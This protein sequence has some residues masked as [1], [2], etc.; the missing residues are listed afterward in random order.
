MAV[1]G[2]SAYATLRSLPPLVASAVRLADSLGFDHSCAP[3]HGLLLSVL[4]RGR[5]GG[6]IGET[7]TGCGVGLA[8][9]VQA[10]DAAT[11]LVSIEV[12][13]ERAEAS[14]ALFADYPNVRVVHGDW[15]ELVD[16]GPFDLLVPDGGGKGKDPS[17]DYPLD[18]TEGWLAPGGTIVL[19]DFI[20]TENPGH[21]STTSPANTGSAIPPYVQRSYDCP[22][23]WL[24]SSERGSDS[25]RRYKPAYHRRAGC[26]DDLCSAS[27]LSAVALSL[28]RSALLESGVVHSSSR[29]PYARAPYAGGH[30]RCRWPESDPPPP[31]QEPSRSNE[32]A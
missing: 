10:T 9:M 5:N 15:T 30:D 22:R 24:P 14:S 17:I 3:E 16:Y 12:D 1:G 23:P 31:S 2:N 4:A 13:R 28:G 25:P 32:A 20:Q 21:P 27:C 29:A 19:D 26:D 6:R 18:P 11:S 7:G 8:W